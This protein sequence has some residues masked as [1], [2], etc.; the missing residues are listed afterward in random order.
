MKQLVL[1]SA[2]IVRALVIGVILAIIGIFIVV[3][4]LATTLH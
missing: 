2:W 1:V 3:C 4:E